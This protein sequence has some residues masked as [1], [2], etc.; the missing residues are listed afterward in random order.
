MTTV[1]EIAK[2]AFDAVAIE[3]SDGVVKMATLTKVTG[4]VHDTATDTFSDGASTAY[5]GRLI[6]TTSKQ[7]MDDYPA[8]T[9]GPNQKPAL[10]I[11]FTTAPEKTDTI[12]VGADTYKVAQVGDIVEVGGLWGLV[13]E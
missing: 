10:A 13:L 1:A 9:V 4:S 8:L 2:E 11:G 6:F 7:L 12:T 5:E 3:F